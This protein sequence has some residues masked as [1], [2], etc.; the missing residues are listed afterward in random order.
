MNFPP[1][2]T[3]FKLY[4]ICLQAKK[5]LQAK[6]IY[7][8]LYSQTYL[9]SLFYTYKQKEWSEKYEFSE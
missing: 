3:Y 4:I 1:S 9:A 8:N 6:K 7:V 5:Y 2:E